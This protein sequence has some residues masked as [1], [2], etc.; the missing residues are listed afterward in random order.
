MP[1]S[2][3]LS[4][5]AGLT[6]EAIL[7]K[8]DQSD[9]PASQIQLLD[10]ETHAGSRYGYGGKYLQSV[11]QHGFDPDD[12]SVMLM[13]RFDAGLLQRCQ[14]Q[15]CLVVSHE[16]PR[17]EYAYFVPPGQ[18]PRID[19]DV[20]AM[21]LATAE[22]SCLL[23]VLQVLDRDLGLLKC[24]L[25][26]VKSA[27]FQDKPGIDELASQ[28]VN[29]LNSREARASVFPQQIAFNLIPEPVDPGVV[30]D[31]SQYLALNGAE[32]ALQSLYAPYFHGF[33]AA[34]QLEFDV[35]V[36]LEQCRETLEAVDNVRV[37]TGLASPISDCN[38]SFSCV[39]SHLQQAQGQTAGV[40]FW[41]IADPL[42]FGLANNYVNLTDF[43]LKSF[44]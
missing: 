34:I 7:E 36:G 43:L 14:S 25:V 16:L 5:A 30:E 37:K 31:L 11:D 40:H 29:L 27:E 44:L 13:T 15:G 22:T 12:C 39:I 42:R 10:D 35:E 2:I 17:N 24:N 26:M 18:E 4:H 33:A 32:M 20:D 6:A 41:M 3:A 38:Q 28:T 9:Y 8:F 23:S 1:Q 21:R 19:M